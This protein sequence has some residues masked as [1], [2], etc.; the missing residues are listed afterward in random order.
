MVVEE[1]R[2]GLWDK[3]LDA[4]IDESSVCR[5][6]VN[7]RVCWNWNAKE[8]V[9]VM[10]LVSSMGFRECTEAILMV[11]ADVGRVVGSA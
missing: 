6:M 4:V 1:E 8:T 7:G 3:A 9:V 10:M 11:L 5:A 2:T